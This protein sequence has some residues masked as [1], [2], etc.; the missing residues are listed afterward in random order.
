MQSKCPDLAFRP[1]RFLAAA[2]VLAGALVLPPASAET[3]R[4]A[5]EGVL[6]RHPDVHSGR[7]LLLA[8]GERIQQARSAFYP[9][10]GLESV[11]AEARDRDLGVGARDRSTRRTDVFLRWNLFRGLAD[12]HALRMAEADNLAAG[13]ELADAQEGVALEMTF[14]YLEVLRLRQRMELAQA[15]LRDSQRLAEDVAKR[16]AAGKVAAADLDQARMSVIEAQWQ[17][18]QLRGQLSGAE[19]RYE[20]LAGHAPDGLEAPDLMRTATLIKREAMMQEVV[21]GNPRV[22][23]VLGRAQA[24]AEEAG[25]AGGAVY[26]TLSMD[27]RKRLQSD[28]DPLPVSDTRDNAQLM[29]NY[30]VPLGGATYSRRREAVARHAAAQATADSVLLAARTSLGQVWSAWDEARRIAPQLAERVETGGRVVS[31]YDLQFAAGRRSLQDLIGIRAEYFRALSEA[32]DNRYEQQQ[33]AAQ[34]LSLLGRLRATVAGEVSSPAPAPQ[35]GAAAV[36]PGLARAG[37]VGS[38]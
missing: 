15:Y 19:A 12:R 18:A 23:A 26:P 37:A 22:R 32:V 38:M 29:F 9:N 2:L 6:Q 16:A 35:A 8:A 36:P 4:Q 30:E 11:A 31:A 28:I 17:L 13:D 3:L 10:V 7:S 33:G 20:L 5:V 24:R 34:V 14:A 27:L 21:A 1:A 25:V